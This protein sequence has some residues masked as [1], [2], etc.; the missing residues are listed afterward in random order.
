MV[1]L[2]VMNLLVGTVWYNCHCRVEGA[3][4]I[5]SSGVCGISN[6]ASL[7]CFFFYFLFPACDLPSC[8]L[9]V[10][11]CINRNSYCLVRF[12]QKRKRLAEDREEKTQYVGDGRMMG[13]IYNKNIDAI[14]YKSG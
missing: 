14:F 11:Y 2:M 7:C 12:V 8:S 4:A 10:F 5:L 6:R 13:S 1:T 9:V 3:A